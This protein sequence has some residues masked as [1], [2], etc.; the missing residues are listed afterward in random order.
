MRL[1]V[2]FRGERHEMVEVEF[3]TRTDESGTRTVLRF[4]RPDD[5]KGTALLV[6]E[7]AKDGKPASYVYLASSEKTKKL[8]SDAA[9]KTEYKGI[10]FSFAELLRLKP[11]DLVSRTKGY[12]SY[13]MDKNGE[14]FTQPY[15]I[16][17]ES[18]PAKGVKTG[19]SRLETVFWPDQTNVKGA[20]TMQ[21]YPVSI[22][23]YDADGKLERTTRVLGLEQVKRADDPETDVLTPTKV[24]AE[25]LAKNQTTTIEVRDP[26]Y[27]AGLAASLFDPKTFGTAND[28]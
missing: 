17:V 15:C 26:K 6:I 5:L 7:K 18:V 21:Y 1:L 11:G 14:P 23:F 27:N 28:G 9:G 22:R 13:T 8:P 10:D 3:L 20:V 12:T 25:H 4:S 24:V 2:D 19:F 16:L